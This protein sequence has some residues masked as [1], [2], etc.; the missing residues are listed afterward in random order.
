MRIIYFIFTF[1]L[2]LSTSQ[3]HAQ[4]YAEFYRFYLSAQGGIPMFWV[5]LS[6][7]GKKFHPGY[8]FN[9]QPGFRFN[10]WISLEFDLGIGKGRL[11]PK[12]WQKDYLI[13]SNGVIAKE[14]GEFLV[15]DIYSEINFY[16]AGFRVP[17]NL[18]NLTSKKHRSFNIELA[19]TLFLNNFNPGLYSK[20]NNKKISD[21][22]NSKFLSYSFGGDLSFLKQINHRT[23]LY[24]RPG[25][26]WLKDERF[27]GITRHDPTNSNLQF[28][29]ALGVRIK[30]GYDRNR[31]IA[32]STS[33]VRVSPNHIRIPKF[34]KSTKIIS[35][36]IKPDPV[37]SNPI[38]LTLKPITKIDTVF[39]KLVSF[40]I[41]SNIQKGVLEE[42]IS[43]AKLHPKA[44]IL[45]E[46]WTD[47][48]GSKGYNQI[49]SER[50]ASTVKNYFI[51]NGIDQYRIQ[52]KGMGIDYDNGISEK[53]R[54]SVIIVKLLTPQ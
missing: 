47:L 5:D 10:D 4:S 2:V 50:R 21:G 1:C 29:L 12:V 8:T 15:K 30:L 31:N 52:T 27:E 46:G 51:E 13:H 9:I 48:S 16:R 14:T 19:H 23:F 25:L 17:V 43:F 26:Y 32:I 35:M 44:T 33:R 53:G 6:T 11:G 38:S 39:Y 45:I 3:V 28:D 18:M 42:V 34:E 54:K 7:I 37:D 49:L 22:Q 20:T 40:E 41:T 36:D 24:F